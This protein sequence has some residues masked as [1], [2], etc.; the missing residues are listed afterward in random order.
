MS[1]TDQEDQEW[2]AS[3]G[4]DRE[5]VGSAAAHKGSSRDPLRCSGVGPGPRFE[6][7]TH[8]WRHT[9]PFF[10]VSLPSSPLSTLF[11][12]CISLLLD[13]YIIHSL[14]RIIKTKSGLCRAVEQDARVT[15]SQPLL[16]PPISSL[17]FLS[18]SFPSSLWPSELQ[19]QPSG[20]E[21]PEF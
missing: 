10:S 18:S 17:F 7:I 20:P 1:S 11:P 9:L 12:P 15:P 5:V 21:N 13:N 3:L 14:K 8:C 6:V 19:S 4:S 16:P 2:S